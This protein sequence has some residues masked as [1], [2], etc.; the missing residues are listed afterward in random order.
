M[1]FKCPKCKKSSWHPVNPDPECLIEDGKVI[2][3]A[4]LQLNLIKWDCDCHKII[5]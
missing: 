4:E 5:K 1:Y 3:K 2:V